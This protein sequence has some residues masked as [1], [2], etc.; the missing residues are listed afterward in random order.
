MLVFFFPPLEK[1][2][3]LAR[4]REEDTPSPFFCWHE[5]EKRGGKFTR[6]RNEVG[7][8]ASFFSCKRRMIN[9][10]DMDASEVILVKRILVTATNTGTRL[11]T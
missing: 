1:S 9:G 11:F 8:F 2:N 3:I 5:I 7:R 10:D 4:H 6:D